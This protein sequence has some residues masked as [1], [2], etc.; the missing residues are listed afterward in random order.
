M[1]QEMRGVDKRSEANSKF[2]LHIPNSSPV[3]PAYLAISTIQGPGV[4]VN[5]TL[6]LAI[7]EIWPDMH[8][9][10]SIG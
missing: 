5:N 3:L 1:Q 6:M 2:L 8:H 4:S 7:S 9:V 10:N